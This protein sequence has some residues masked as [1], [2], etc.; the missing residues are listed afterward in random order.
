[1]IFLDSTCTVN[2]IGPFSK[3]FFRNKVR[4]TIPVS[5]YEVSSFNHTKHFE[6]YQEHQY[7][8]HTFYILISSNVGNEIYDFWIGL[9]IVA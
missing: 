3:G 2:K 1:M 6:Y 5:P 8:H 7:P 9:E 4:C